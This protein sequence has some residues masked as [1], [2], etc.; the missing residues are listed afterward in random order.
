VG[1]RYQADA[2]LH[3]QKMDVGERDGGCGQY[4]RKSLYWTGGAASWHGGCQRISSAWSDVVPGPSGFSTRNYFAPADPPPIAMSHS[5][6]MG[7]IAFSV[8]AYQCS[9]SLF[10]AA[11]PAIAM[12][13]TSAPSRLPRIELACVRGGFS[14]KHIDLRDLQGGACLSACGLLGVFVSQIQTGL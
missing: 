13:I 2:V 3:C 4:R 11:G 6:T 1:G 12:F 14:K 7:C 9:V 5:P 8:I 10:D